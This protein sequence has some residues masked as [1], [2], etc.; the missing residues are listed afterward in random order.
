MAEYIAQQIVSGSGLPYMANAEMVGGINLDQEGKYMGLPASSAAS[1]T[2]STILRSEMTGSQSIIHALNKLASSVDSSNDLGFSADS[3]VNGEVALSSQT[4]ALIGTSNEIE[5]SAAGAQ[6]LTIGLPDDVTIADQLTVTGRAVVDDTTEATTTTDGSLQTD[7]G[8]SVA[9]SAVIGDDLDLLSDGAILSIGSTSKFVLTDQSANNA[10]MAAANA[11]L[12]FG[13]AGE[14]I[15]GDG[16]DLSII[17]SGDVDMTATLFDV[18]GAGTF[19]GILKTDDATEATSGTDGSLQTDGGL[20]VV[21]KAYIGD[22]LTVAGNEID[23]V[24]G[25]ASFGASVGANAITYGGG[26][27]QHVFSSADAGVNTGISFGQVAATAASQ[28]GAFGEAKFLSSVTGSANPGLV[29]AK[30]AAFAISASVDI[31]DSGAPG[32]ILSAN[33]RLL[34]TAAVDM[35]NKTIPFLSIQGADATGVLRDY[36]LQVSG[37]ILQVNQYSKLGNVY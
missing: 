16:T 15:T 29:A 17:S 31:R 18:T 27:T 3:G 14:Y 13:N 34:D 2:S 8:L 20:S 9:K 1:G 24:A 32:T 6:T 12:A 35:F 19:S 28:A 11:R 36:K 37:G 7:G 30:V 21:K 10:V 25:A 26:F 33:G 23:F 5:T 22:D 4:F